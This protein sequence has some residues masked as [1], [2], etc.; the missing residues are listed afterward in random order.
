M[1]EEIERLEHH[2]HLLAQPIDGITLGEDILAVD[3]DA[4][5]SGL[6]QQVQTS[7]EGAL[8]SARR[9]DDGYDLTV[10]NIYV[11]VAQHIERTVALLQVG[12]VKYWRVG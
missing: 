8:A 7:Q 5:T 1:F 10:M 9:T 4:A 12:D 11:N 6:F 2:T 3:N